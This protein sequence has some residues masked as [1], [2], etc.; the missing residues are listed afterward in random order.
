MK[1]IVRNILWLGFLLFSLL[2]ISPILYSTSAN[3]SSHPSEVLSLPSADSSLDSTKR[4]LIDVAHGYEVFIPAKVS[5]MGAILA[6]RGY[7]IIPLMK[8][9]RFN[10][11]ILATADCIMIQTPDP[12]MPYTQNEIDALK[13]YWDNGGSLLLI[14]CSQ[15]APIARPNAEIN[16]VMTELDLGAKF[17]TYQA[18]GYNNS[19][20][21]HPV[22]QS[23]ESIFVRAA[24]IV[25][26]PSAPITVLTSKSGVAT[27][28]A[29]E[30]VTLAQR[31]VI[32][33]DVYPLDEFTNLYS[34]Q[35]LNYNNYTNHYQFILNIFQWL[36]H[37]DY[38]AIGSVTP[39]IM[40]TYGHNLATKNE[41][42]RLNMV[43]GLIHFHVNLPPD[44][45]SI[46]ISQAIEY[47]NDLNYSFVVLSSHDSGIHIQPMKDYR[48]SK[49]YDIA[50]VGGEELSNGN[51]FHVLTFGINDTVAS[52]SD[53]L[54]IINYLH[55][56]SLPAFLCHPSWDL[57]PTH[58]RIWD[59]DLYPFDGYELA[60]SYEAHGGRS[61]AS[62]YPWYY[63]SDTHENTKEWFARVQNYI[64]TDDEVDD[65]GAWL[66]EAIFDRRIAA[67]N[68]KDDLYAGD[69]IV[70]DEVLG[71][72]N[73]AQAP[74]ISIT[75]TE[76]PDGSILVTA[77]IQD[78]SP[79]ASVAFTVNG[80]PT[81]ISEDAANYSIYTT[82]IGP[83]GSG[84]SLTLQITST[85]D[86]GYTGQNSTVYL[87]V[88][89]TTSSSITSSETTSTS[90]ATSTTPTPGLLWLEILVIAFL[91]SVLWKK[92]EKHKI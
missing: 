21:P 61:L 15:Y 32:L 43:K 36:T 45:G 67:Y 73:D 66:G 9:D 51:R 81:T 85:D 82:T 79:L 26:D 39:I 41:L 5:P 34:A 10:S 63:A 19:M 2:L 69:Q 90:S 23:L 64:L 17:G 89:G 87:V 22:T 71:R 59:H 29:Y 55:N 88:Y 38:A 47:A 78:D 48:N 62:Q 58:P 72:L 8:G 53:P 28:A 77:V 13:T 52:P 37:Q 31:A 91:L 80:Q 84:E 86:K 11:S 6:K 70:L 92:R 75:P 35:D 18:G 46:T 27:T 57:S 4:I 50:V 44:D 74:E 12:T 25:I 68:A 60:N 42:R 1:M 7:E 83:Y 33:G 40:Y 30:N 14:G 20:T 56:N 49:G 16:R 65:A 3:T 76:Y 54:E 24:D